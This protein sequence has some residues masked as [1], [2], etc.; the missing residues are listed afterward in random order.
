MTA[1]A[2]LAAVA[3]IVYLNV[4]ITWLPFAA[5]GGG[6]GM[7]VLVMGLAWG[8]GNKPV[9]LVLVGVG[10]G[11]DGRGADE[12]D[13]AAGEYLCGAAGG[14]LDGRECVRAGLGACADDWNMAGGAAA[15]LRG[16]CSAAE[17]A[18][19]WGTIW[20][21]GWGCGRGGCGGC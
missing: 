7:A 4:P 11:V 17:C 1:G 21:R 3:V 15:G 13:D 14:D 2:S 9:R 6:L 8:G 5:F 19:R 20:R 18:G 10:M 16:G 12:F